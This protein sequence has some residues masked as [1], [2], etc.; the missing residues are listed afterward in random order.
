MNVLIRQ[1]DE[2]DLSCFNALEA[3]LFPSEPWGE[4]ALAGHLAASHTLSLLAFENEKPVG[5]LLAGFSPPESELYRIAV[6]P[7]ARRR[8][9]GRRLLD[10]LFRS[11]A[12]RGVF[13][14]WLEVR[15]SNRAAET[16]YLSAGFRVVSRRKRYYRDPAEAALVMTTECPKESL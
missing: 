3:R 15:E 1:A 14:I 13:A 5:Y 6:L 2:N 10:E 7:E 11:A 9:Y 8:G 4:P 16:L 12:E